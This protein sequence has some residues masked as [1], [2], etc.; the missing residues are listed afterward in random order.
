MG[1]DYSIDG[2]FCIRLDNRIADFISS[3]IDN[4]NENLFNELA[5]KEFEYQYYANEVYQGFCKKLDVKPGP[6]DGWEE[7][8]IVPSRAFK[9]HIIASFPID[10]LELA[11]M[12]G[13]TMDAQKRG[14]IYRDKRA[15]DL[16][17][18]AN[19]LMTKSFLFP[20][21]EKM[22]I[23]LM[24]P[25]PKTVPLMGM[26]IGLEQTRLNFGT[27][28]SMYLITPKGLRIKE[29]FDC[30][31][32]AEK[33]GEPLALIGATSGFVYFFN[34][35]RKEKIKFNLPYSSRICDGG[36]YSGRFG[37]CSK[38]EYFQKCYEILG[39]SKEFCVNTYGTGESSTNY[40]DNVL[41]NKVLGVEESRSKTSPPWARTIIVDVK[42]FKKIPKGEVGLIRHY[43]LT[44]R[45][46]IFGV[47]TDNLGYETDNGFE[48]IGR[49][50]VKDGL[51]RTTPVDKM[52]GHMAE[53]RVGKIMDTVLNFMMRYQIP[54]YA[55]RQRNIK[56]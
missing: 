30:L 43:D 44:N 13:G 21:V 15:V 16:V 1:I 50:G 41:R 39:I 25:S 8:P 5:L 2:A 20:D 56:K 40:F 28:D 33:T 31:R 46:M 37:E 26:A 23:L 24:S 55:K 52:V 6:I 29:L 7:I 10:K 27:E 14:K 54:R 3:G 11:Y 18:K 9:D 32:N 48:I 38:E 51:I 36:G 22:K 12:T 42:S 35:C 49:A 4:Q 17:F 53:R 47:Q 34:A 45:A 19:T